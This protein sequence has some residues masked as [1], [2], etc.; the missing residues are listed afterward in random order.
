MNLSPTDYVHFD[1]RAVT[2]TG[3]ESYSDATHLG[4][5]LSLDR[6]T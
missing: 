4:E 3:A 5:E 2:L 1:E 6:E